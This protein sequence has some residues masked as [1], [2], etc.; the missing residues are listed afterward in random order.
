MRDQ[1][2]RD[3]PPRLRSDDGS[4]SVEAALA[5]SSLVIVCGLIIA[6]MATLAAYLAAVDTAGAAARAHA[7][8]EHF[9]PTRG[10]LDVQEISGML[11]ATATIPA[12]FGEVS[13]RAVF[14]VEN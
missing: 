9:E 7:I 13:A 6:A 5:L 11:T 4:V 10:Q 14:P 12:P 8:G 2:Q 1:N 3:P